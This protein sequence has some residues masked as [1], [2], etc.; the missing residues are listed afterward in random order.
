[1]SDIGLEVLRCSRVCFFNN[2]RKTLLRTPLY[3]TLSN[4][5]DA[6]SLFLFGGFPQHK[7]GWGVGQE[8]GIAMKGA[9]SK[10]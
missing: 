1:M 4:I 7:W 6:C 8:D 10:V 5:A 9:Q 3:R 2:E